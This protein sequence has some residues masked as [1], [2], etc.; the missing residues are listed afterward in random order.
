MDQADW[1]R[2]TVALRDVDDVD[3]A[4]AAATELHTTASHEDVPR[5]VALLRDPSF[6]VRE[7]AAWP[8]AELAGAAHLG[9]LLHAYQ[10]GL[11]E[12]HD[13][14]GFS[15][16]LLEMAAADPSGLR[17]AL[18]PFLASADPELR[19]HAEWLIEFCEEGA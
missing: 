17:V 19:G 9:E 18:V 11:D 6:F 3:A 1:H 14:D 4:V 10:R 8:L 13:N 2:L 12:R 7:A 15:A 5:L 16:A